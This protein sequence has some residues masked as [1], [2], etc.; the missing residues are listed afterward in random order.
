[1]HCAIDSRSTDLV[2]YLLDLGIT[3]N[4]YDEGLWNELYYAISMEN[5]DMV[6][7]LINRG[8]KF[9]SN[10]AILYFCMRKGRQF[11]LPLK[12]RLLI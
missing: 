10:D 6:D 4:I 5:A 9:D 11:I 3:I 7:I 8:C 1:M 2:S 12:D